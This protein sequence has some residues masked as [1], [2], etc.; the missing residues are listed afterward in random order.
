MS[1]TI[2]ITGTSNGF[3]NDIATTL[4]AAGHRVFATMRDV[5][6][7][8]REAAQKLNEKGIETLELDV[9]DDAS[10]DAAFKALFAKTNGKLDVLINNAGV[11]AGGLQETFT[12][13][14]TRAMFD[15]NVFGIQ[16]VTRAALPNMHKAKSGLI[17]NIGS[18]LGR[19]TLPF[20]A[21]YGASKHAVEALT[22][23]Y[24]YELSQQGIDVVL[25]QPGPYPTKLYT[26][27]Q[28]PADLGRADNYGDVAKMPAAFEEFLGGLFSSEQA[29]DPH[30]VAKTIV[31]LIEKPAG[32]RPNRAIVGLDFGADAANTAI[33][34][35][36]AKLVADIG[37]NQ[38]TVLKTS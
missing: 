13:E 9:T 35:I 12:P 33:Q 27:I 31:A 22:E 18:I 21:L 14:Q 15:V 20:F 30:D 28:K 4:A 3:G 6:G 7:R 8:H 23:G 11:A 29:P 19:V 24:R 16:R 5:N 10:V 25:V 1:K 26:A 32:Q 37:M 36:Q 2:L 38:L 17:V 34:P